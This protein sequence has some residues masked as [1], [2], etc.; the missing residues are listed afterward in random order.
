MGERIKKWTQI[1]GSRFELEEVFRETIL[2]KTKNAF[3]IAKIIT[4]RKTPI[5]LYAGMVRN[6]LLGIETSVPDYDFIGDFNLDQIQADF[7]ELVIG[8]WDEFDTIR[9]RAGSY[10]LDF[11]AAKDMETRLAITDMTISTLVLSEDGQITDYFGGLESLHNREVK[12]DDPELKITRD[13]SRILR[14]LR[15]A[16]ELGFTIE[17]HTLAAIIKHAPLLRG[18]RNLDDEIWQILALEE[19]VRR[20]VLQALD[21]YGVSRYLSIPEGVIAAIDEYS[22]EKDIQRIPQVHEVARML[23]PA[24]VYLGGGAVR[25]LIWGKKINDLDFEVDLPLEEIVRILEANGYTKIDDYQTS[26][27]QYYIST[28]AGVVGAVVNGVDVHFCVMTD[29]Q[30]STLLKEG[31]VNFSCC[32]FNARTGKVENPEIIREIK[33]KRLLFCDAEHASVDPLIIV[34]ALKQVARVPG[35]VVPPETRQIL[36]SHIPNVVTYFREHPEMKYK[37]ASI[38]GHLNSEEALIFFDSIP[39][40]ADVFQDIDMKK[41]KL[42]V[43]GEQYFSQRIEELSEADKAEIV[44][45]IQSAFGAKY[46]PEKEFPEKINSVVFERQN[47]RIVACGLVDGERV[48]VASA[49]S[50][51]DW[52]S[53]FANLDQNNYN[54]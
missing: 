31:D 33:E 17:D 1:K 29:G 27:H 25:D 7:P 39:G 2:G 26:E 53:I 45:L 47:G 4:K 19:P 10:S 23:E 46:K 12:M 36:E 49:K 38:C 52:I 54:V 34:N 50:G 21:Q 14:A 6:L 51:H 35:V 42:S 48:Y 28:F 15:F 18:V 3:E 22:L 8:R 43:S 11:T 40:C 44:Q 13:P 32:V 37:L 20:E 9:L 30:V 16:S 5:H 41:P 24:Q